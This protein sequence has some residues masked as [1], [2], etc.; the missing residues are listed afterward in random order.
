MNHNVD[1]RKIITILNVFFSFLC[2]NID[3]KIRILIV[4][5]YFTYIVLNLYRQDKLKNIN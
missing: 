1:V 2:A 5:L 4:I 3:H